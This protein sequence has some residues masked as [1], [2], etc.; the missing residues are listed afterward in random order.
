MMP[1]NLPTMSSAHPFKGTFKQFEQFPISV[2]PQ[3]ARKHTD[4]ATSSPHGFHKAKSVFL[5]PK[6]SCAE[7][8]SQTTVP[9]GKIVGLLQPTSDKSSHMRPAL[10]NLQAEETA[11]G[12]EKDH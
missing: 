6:V 12:N 7:N 8:S 5:L 1:K 10:V 9:S 11:A 2:H 3:D 4:E